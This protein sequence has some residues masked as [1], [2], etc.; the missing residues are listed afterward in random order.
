MLPGPSAGNIRSQRRTDSYGP[1]REC[2]M[3]QM[4][5][6]QEGTLHFCVLPFFVLTIRSPSGPRIA[7]VDFHV[8]MFERVLRRDEKWLLVRRI[9]QNAQIGRHISIWIC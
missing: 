2:F 1:Q 4:Y 9:E 8:Y 7:D 6:G 5:I 3:S